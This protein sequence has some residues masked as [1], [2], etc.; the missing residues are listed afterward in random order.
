MVILG[1]LMQ[2]FVEFDL[3]GW[4]NTLLS[5]VTV[6]FLGLPIGVGV[7]LL[8][9][10]LRKELNLI[11]LQLFVASLGMT[12]V[13]Y[14]SPIQ[15]IIFTLMTLLY[16]PCLATWITIRKEAGRR[17][18]AHVLLFRI[19][20]AVIISGVIYWTFKFVSNLKPSWTFGY[21]ITIT[22]LIF[23]IFLYIVVFLIG[24]LI[25][26]RRKGKGRRFHRFKEFSE[27]SRCENCSKF[28]KCAREK[29]NKCEEFGEF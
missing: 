25:K 13:D 7:Y 6:H 24:K 29:N 21:Q 27:I 9:G 28:N 14:L 10:I 12:M 11:L 19:T 22:V 15:M 3:L 5:P 8:Y 20:I 16:I 2:I 1:V 23:F 18:A 26:H 17:F 4:M